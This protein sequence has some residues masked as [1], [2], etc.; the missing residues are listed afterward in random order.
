MARNRG[1]G[2]CSTKSTLKKI[3]FYYYL[4]R[5]MTR[6]QIPQQPGISHQVQHQSGLLQNSFFFLQETERPKENVLLN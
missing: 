4:Y 6:L 5:G 1:S 3:F 2:F